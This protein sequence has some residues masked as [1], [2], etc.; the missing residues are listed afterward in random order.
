M[1]EE[2]TRKSVL[3]YED[4][5]AVFVGRC[6]QLNV[7]ADPLLAALLSLLEE[8]STMEKVKAHISEAK[9]A[10]EANKQR[11]KEILDKLNGLSTDELDR[12]LRAM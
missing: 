9:A 7:S 6:R 4:C 10:V 5:H 11:K 1:K 8:P 2:Q 3:I 12:L